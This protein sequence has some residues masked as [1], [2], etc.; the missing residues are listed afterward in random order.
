MNTFNKP[1]RK[2]QELIAILR[3][4]G[5]DIPDEVRARHYLSNISYFRLSAYTRRF[6]IPNITQ[7][8]FIKGTTFEDVLN[9]YIF[10]RELRVLLM[11]AI[12]RLE[13]SL[14]AQ[15]GNT[16]AE[17]YDPH[18][19]LNPNVFD[20]RYDHAWLVRTLDEEVASREVETFVEHYRSKYTGAP[21]QPPVW[22][23]MELLTFSVVSRLF[24]NLRNP[25]DTS[26]I[27]AHYGVPFPVLKSWFRSV[28]DMRNLCA[29][30]MRVWNREFGTNPMIPHRPPKNWPNIPA[31][32]SVKSSI[33]SAQSLNPQ[34]RLY[35]QL[36]VIQYLMSV[37]CPNSRWAV[38]LVQLL[39]RYPGISRVHMGFP[40]DWEK[41]A[42]WRDALNHKP[43]TVP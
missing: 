9:L 17:H 18:G 22:M 37:V 38:R 5:L 43:P 21:K 7:H 4:R 28:A 32:I 35:M 30:H 27:S 40:P 31:S 15:L 20:T 29:H 23:A 36:V 2:P 24:G 25:K 10:D 6:Y 19:Y 33:H 34:R 16:L 3:E 41:E 13:V 1:F 11:D 26:K 42:M 39:D 12:E 8:Q 14:R